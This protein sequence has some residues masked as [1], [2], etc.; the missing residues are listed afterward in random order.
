MAGVA[1]VSQRGVA[2]MSWWKS[3]LKTLGMKALELA[4]EE[5]KQQIKKPRTTKKIPQ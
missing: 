5:L 1:S 4:G 3:L 2:L